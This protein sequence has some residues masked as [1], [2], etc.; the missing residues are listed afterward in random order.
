MM[1][2]QQ[3]TLNSFAPTLHHYNYNPTPNT[4]HIYPKLGI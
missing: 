1:T 3:Q 2:P 4:Y